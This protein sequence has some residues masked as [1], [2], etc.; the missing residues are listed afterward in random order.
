MADVAAKDARHVLGQRLG[1]G[2]NVNLVGRRSTYRMGVTAGQAVPTDMV[3]AGNPTKVILDAGP[4]R[5]LDT[6][7]AHGL[8]HHWIIAYGDARPQLRHLCHLFGIPCIPCTPT[9]AD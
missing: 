5:Y 1:H 2:K 4:Q 7:A 9:P 6:V 8:G 3:F